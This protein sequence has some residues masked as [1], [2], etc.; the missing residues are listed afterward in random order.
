LLEPKID[1]ETL[2][3]FHVVTLH[4]S[5]H[6]KMLSFFLPNKNV[7]EI[8]PSFRAT[9]VVKKHLRPSILAKRQWW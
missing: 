7:G 1:T 4:P 6:R 2:H 9:C 8:K 5:Q 3:A